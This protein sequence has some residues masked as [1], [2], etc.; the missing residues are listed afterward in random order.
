MGANEIEGD[1]TPP[2][3]VFAHDIFPPNVPGGLQAVFSGPGQ[4]PFIDLNW[5]PVMQSDL[6]GYNIY[7]HEA[8]QPAVKINTE[9]VKTPAYH[10]T[11]VAP[12]KQY[13]Y[14]V[15]AVD[16]PGNESARSEEASEQV[17]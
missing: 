9:P 17:Q 10:D 2:V 12:G 3:K 7:R 11:N 6:T 5:A 4:Q 1:D 15:T 14:A 8:N 16:T 13:F